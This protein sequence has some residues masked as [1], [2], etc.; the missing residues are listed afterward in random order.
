[1]HD[2]VPTFHSSG[3]EQ[4][5]SSTHQSNHA[6]TTLVG[7]SSVRALDHVLVLVVGGGGVTSAECPG[8]GR[9]VRG[10]RGLGRGGRIRECRRLG[11]LSRIRRRLAVL[12]VQNTKRYKQ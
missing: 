7:I 6:Q 1:M 5:G 10:E 4:G 8:R 9:N 3:H 11:R 12:G 2:V